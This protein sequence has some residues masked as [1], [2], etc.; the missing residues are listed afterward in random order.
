MSLSEEWRPIPGF[1]GYEVSDTGFIRSWRGRYGRRAEPRT[2]S[3]RTD[4][5]GYIT[6]AIQHPDGRNM[7]VLVHR[8]V[9]MAFHGLPPEGKPHVCH[10]DGNPANNTPGNLRWGSREDNAQDQI[11][12]G[13]HLHARKTACKYGHPYTKESINYRGGRIC[14]IC[15]RAADNARY[16]KYGPRRS[17]GG[18]QNV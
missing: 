11:R 7:P 5:A 10:W 2:L 16:R 3:Q 14:R 4:P 17:A 6:T 9:C 18:T 15:T 13:R 8:M 12:H 1:D